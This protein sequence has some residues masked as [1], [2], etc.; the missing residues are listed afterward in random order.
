M[1]ERLR[2]L[3]AAVEDLEQLGPLDAARLRGER[4]TLRVVERC[5]AH[6]VDL[7]AQIN[8]HAAAATSGR[9]PRDLTESFDLA[10]AAGVFEQSLADALRASAGMRNVIVHAYAELDLDRVAAA[11][12][13]AI[14]GYREYVAQV[15]AFVQ[16]R[17][18][19]DGPR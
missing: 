1:L 9:T 16:A 19:D 14:T 11:V 2:L 12:P 6:L 7:A 8:A 4:T 13:M 10:A 17:D 5:L 3:V 15:A 18:E